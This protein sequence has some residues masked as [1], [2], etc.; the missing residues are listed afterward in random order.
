MPES[1]ERL[2]L[3][4]LAA[5]AATVYTTPATP[6]GSAS[7]RVILRGIRCVSIG[8]QDYLT[9]SI[10]ADAAA[11]RLFHR[12]PVAANG[13]GSLDWTGFVVLNPNDI[14]QAY[15]ATASLLTLSLYGVVWSP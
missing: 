3:G 7:G 2:Y 12:E 8:A 1:P 11:A 6:G 4:Q 14:V 15:A 9:L 5:A 10:G 13:Q